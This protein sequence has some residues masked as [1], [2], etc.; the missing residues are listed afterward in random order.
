VVPPWYGG[1][2]STTSSRS[3]GSAL[4]ICQLLP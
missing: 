1:R 4:I 2:R 3:A